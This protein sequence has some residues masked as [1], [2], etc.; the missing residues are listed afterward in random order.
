MRYVI[1]KPLSTMR[2][3]QSRVRLISARPTAT[4]TSLHRVLSCRSFQTGAS[5]RECGVGGYYVLSRTVLRGFTLSASRGNVT[6]GETMAV[7]ATYL[8]ETMADSRSTQHRRPNNFRSATR[9]RQARAIPDPTSGS[10]RLPAVLA[11]HVGVGALSYAIIAEDNMNLREFLRTAAITICL[12]SFSFLIGFFFHIGN[13][14][15]VYRRSYLSRRGRTHPALE[16]DFLGYLD[17][18][19][20]VTVLEALGVS[21]RT[22]SLFSYFSGRKIHRCDQPIGKGYHW[23]DPA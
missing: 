4:A 19:W 2:S 12:R 11:Q 8:S 15:K 3:S 7:T 9:P 16:H 13:M 6:V 14:R 22:S 23:N 20:F 1:G 10:A 18:D 21:Y 17:I 5:L